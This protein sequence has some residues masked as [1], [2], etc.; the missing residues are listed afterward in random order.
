MRQFR[1]L[2][3]DEPVDGVS[4][5]PGKSIVHQPRL[6]SGLPP[7]NG[8]ARLAAVT[9]MLKSYTVRDW[10]AFAENFGIPVTVGKYGP[11]AT[12]GANPGAD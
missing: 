11:N 3:D 5:T 10:R 1:L 7:R 4:P 8:L 2:T 12:G 9:Y 6:K